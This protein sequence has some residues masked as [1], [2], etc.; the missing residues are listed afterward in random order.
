M[1]INFPVPLSILRVGGPYSISLHDMSSSKG[2]ICMRHWSDRGIHGKGP[3]IDYMYGGEG[4]H[5]GEIA[6]LIPFA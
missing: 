4:L 1:S 3:V 2:N 6:G 5:Q